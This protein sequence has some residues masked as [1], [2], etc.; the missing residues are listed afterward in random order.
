MYNYIQNFS[1]EINFY[2]AELFNLPP[3]YKIIL[4]FSG[5]H[6]DYYQMR[7]SEEE[8]SIKF[9]VLRSHLKDLNKKF[10]QNNQNYKQKIKTYIEDNKQEIDLERA[11]F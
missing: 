1:L 3:Q 7:I 8:I 11:K 10:I 2:K 4:D 5:N 9:E 6:E